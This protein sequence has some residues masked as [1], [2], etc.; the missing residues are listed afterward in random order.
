[1]VGLGRQKEPSDFH[2][3][4]ISMKGRGRRGGGVECLRPQEREC[5]EQGPES[6]HI[7]GLHLSVF[8]HCYDR[9][10]KHLWTLKKKKTCYLAHSVGNRKSKWPDPS[11]GEGIPTHVTL[12]QIA[13]WQEYVWQRSHTTRQGSRG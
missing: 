7:L 12:Q 5:S 11:S 4:P 13:L 9:I 2:R 6:S 10:P 1:M 8:L 3:G